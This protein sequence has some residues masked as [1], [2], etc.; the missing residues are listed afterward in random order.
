MHVRSVR[1]RCS[2]KHSLLMQNTLVVATTDAHDQAS[3]SMAMALL[4]RTDWTSMRERDCEGEMWQS[5]S[6]PIILILLALILSFVYSKRSNVFMWL[7]EDGLVRNDHID[8]RFQEI[9]GVQPDDVL[10]LSRHAS[11]SGSPALTVHPIGNPGRAEAE[12]GGIPNRCPPPS[13]RLASL[14]RSLYK[15]TAASDLKGHFD[16]SLEGTHHGPWLTTPS[17]F[18]EIGRMTISL[19]ARPHTLMN[20]GST[21]SEWTR[22]DAAMHWADVLVEELRIEGGDEEGEQL[23]AEDKAIVVVGLGG[24]HYAPRHGDVARKDGV[25]LGHILPSYTLDFSSSEWKSTV[26]EAIDSS[27]SAFERAGRA[28]DVVCHLDKKAFRSADREMLKHL[29]V[30]H[31]YHVAMSPAE[32]DKIVRGAREELSVSP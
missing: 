9:T 28:V 2:N 3:F 12:A 5:R 17:L 8:R 13:P 25:F 32:A 1:A 15:K 6:E 10:F 14:Y 27:A 18:A 7:L 29:L 19:L 11:A 22:Q 23:S 31:G 26:L 16:V 20:S 24:G 4:R 30:S 21:E